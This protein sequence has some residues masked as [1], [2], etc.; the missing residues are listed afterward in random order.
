M[1]TLSDLSV[2]RT[3]L[4]PSLERPR[5]TT[6]IEDFRERLQPCLED[7]ITQKTD[8]YSSYTD[9]SL[10][11]TIWNYPQ[12]MIKARGKRI[13]P[14]VAYLMYR[15]LSGDDKKPLNIL[16]S[17]E[18]FHLFCLVHDDIIDRGSQRHNLPTLHRFVTA[19]LHADNRLHDPEHIGKAQAILLGDILFAWSQEAFHGNRDFSCGTIHEARR[20]FNL[21]IDEVVI[22]EMMD[23]DMMT[24]RAT[25]LDAIDK[26]I[27]LK[28]ASYTF[29]RPLQ[30]GAALAGYSLSYEKF[31]Y[32]LGLS[33]GAA[34]QIQDD[35][36]DLIGTPETTRKSLFSDLR[37][38][39]HTY[40]TQYIFEHGTPN[41]QVKL[42]QL[43]G[44]EVGPADRAEVLNLFECSG[45]LAHGQANIRRHLARACN[46]IHDSA[47]PIADKTTFYDLI[48]L[49]RDRAL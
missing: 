37:E 38:H 9:D 39:Q 6:D 17:L 22:G 49:I 14:Y 42:R 3:A 32:D 46:L 24:R 31:C 28:T 45:A 5:A 1:T 19:K 30:I 40:F 33:L 15:A 44:A 20:F 25:S 18:L 27:L 47:L 7:F 12:R 21:M 41:E 11:V 2:P 36:L 13:R 35:L 48:G 8:G 23:V 10:L 34:F 43:L 26:K 29:I 16:I 4:V